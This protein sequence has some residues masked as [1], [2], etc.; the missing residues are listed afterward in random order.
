M[1]DGSHEV[2][3][4]LSHGST[5]ISKVHCGADQNREGDQASSLIGAVSRAV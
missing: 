4:G 5:N 3:D 2:V 1:P